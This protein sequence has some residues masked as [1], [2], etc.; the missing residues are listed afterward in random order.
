MESLEAK[1]SEIA[2][3]IIEEILK[4]EEKKKRK[5][6]NLIDKSLGVL[7]NDGVYAYYVFI[8]SQKD[9]KTAFIFLDSMEELFN[10]AKNQ[11]PYDN[12]NPHDYFKDVASDINKLLFLKQLL[13]KTLIYAR[14]HAKALEDSNE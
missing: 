10:I 3:M 4:L 8:I 2:Y 9:D 5:L 12:S 7:S 1:I 11:K 6:I 14:Y 13:E